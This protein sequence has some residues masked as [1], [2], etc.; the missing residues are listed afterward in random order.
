ML[1][2]EHAFEVAAG[3]RN[4]ARAIEHV[5]SDLSVGSVAVDRVEVV[6]LEGPKYEPER[7]NRQV[8]RQSKIP[9]S[10]TSGCPTP[11]SAAPGRG[12]WLKRRT[13]PASAATHS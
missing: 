13:S 2:R 7:S 8:Q 4:R 11:C 3:L 1:A 9:M 5:S 10:G 12:G 6:R